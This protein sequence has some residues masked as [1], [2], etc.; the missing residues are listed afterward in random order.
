MA[1]TLVGTAEGQATNGAAIS[2]TLPGGIAQNDLVVVYESHDGAALSGM[3]TAG[4]TTNLTDTAGSIN[5]AVYW[6]FMGASPDATAAL[7]TG[8]NSRGHGAIAFVLRGV[9]TSTPIDAT[10]TT[11]SATST[12]PDPASITTV[13]N[14]A[15]V[16]ACAA[17]LVADTS[18]TAPSG[19]SNQTDIDSNALTADV[20]IGVASKEITTAGAENPASWTTWSSAAWKTATVALRPSTSVAT[21]YG[22]NMPM[23][24]M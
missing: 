10:T 4:Y 22:F 2:L 24:G 6:K 21:V 19:Y 20:T 17:S 5:Q 8:T 1:I 12:N 13:T 11:A 15:W 18:V 14:G 16:L 23:L 9:D 3:S 7:N